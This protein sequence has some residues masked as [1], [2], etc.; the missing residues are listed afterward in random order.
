[1]WILLFFAVCRCAILQIPLIKRIPTDLIHVICDHLQFRDL[2]NLAQTDSFFK[3][4]LN[5]EITNISTNNYCYDYTNQFHV[6]ATLREAEKEDVL[7]WLLVHKPAYDYLDP[8]DEYF[9]VPDLCKSIQISKFSV[10][11]FWNQILDEVDSDIQFDLVL[12]DNSFDGIDKQSLKRIR[13]IEVGSLSDENIDS[14]ETLEMHVDVHAIV[15]N[16]ESNVHQSSRILRNPHLQYSILYFMLDPVPF[17]ME[18]R[19]SIISIFQNS[20]FNK[21]L[22]SQDK[23]HTTI[24]SKESLENLFERDYSS[25]Y[26][27]GPLLLKGFSDD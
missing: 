20:N 9:T 15:F 2:I 25:R 16:P 24:C 18:V 12:N 8:N 6:L 10:L 22:H 13:V 3:E 27:Q 5:E 21:F 23:Y 17:R 1:M 11:S 4:I 7:N 26:H 19:Q 14:M